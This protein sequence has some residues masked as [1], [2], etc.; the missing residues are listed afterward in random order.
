MKQSK[1]S[2]Q[3]LFRFIIKVF[4]MTFLLS[5]AIPLQAGI[6]KCVSENGIE[7]SDTH[8]STGVLVKHSPGYPAISS[9][10]GLTQ[11]ELELL[12]EMEKAYRKSRVQ[13]D[14]YSSAH[15]KKL[16]RERA[17]KRQDYARSCARAIKALEQLRIIKR[18]GYSAKQSRGLDSREDLLNEQKRRNC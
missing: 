12:Y 10:E 2:K 16:H 14:Q 5:Q 18:K 7:Y 1:Q 13:A 17:R 4:A 11:H 3:Y 15:K 9:I 8:C 6:H